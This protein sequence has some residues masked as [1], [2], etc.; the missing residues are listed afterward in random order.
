MEIEKNIF[1]FII[2]TIFVSVIGAIAVIAVHQAIKN[3]ST[4]SDLQTNITSLETSFNVLQQKNDNDLKNVLRTGDEVAIVY[5]S[6]IKGTDP[7]TKE[8]RLGSPDKCSGEG[9]DCVINFSGG[10]SA[11]VDGGWR[12]VKKNK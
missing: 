5:L 11:G 1:T 10:I 2:Y 9:T 7:K 12:L 6:P 4:V 3:N 8:W